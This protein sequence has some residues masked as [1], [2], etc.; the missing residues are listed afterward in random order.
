MFNSWPWPKVIYILKLKLAFLRNHWAIF[1]QI[2]YVSF[3]SRYKEMKIY[4]YD[5][6]HMT[7]M[8]AMTIY[9]KKPF[10]NLFRNQ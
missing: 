8:A 6:C 5:V 7:K 3:K 4:K 2:L 9:G 10:K 1:Y